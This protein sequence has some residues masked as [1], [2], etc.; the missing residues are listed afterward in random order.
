MPRMTAYCKEAQKICKTHTG[1]TLGHPYGSFFVVAVDSIQFP[2]TH[3]H[4]QKGGDWL[5]TDEM[6]P[7]ADH[8]EAWAKDR[9]SKTSQTVQTHT[10]EA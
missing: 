7:R 4:V 9:E 6:P 5:G 10:A 1:W 8:V 3:A 2:L